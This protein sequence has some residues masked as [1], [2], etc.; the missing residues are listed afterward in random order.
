MATLEQ[1]RKQLLIFILPLY[2]RNQ[3]HAFY[4][5]VTMTT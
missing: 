5:K 4:Q 3:V 1:W 2:K